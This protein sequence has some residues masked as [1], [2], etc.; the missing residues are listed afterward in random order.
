MLTE[1]K[2]MIEY[3]SR[4]GLYML[5]IEGQRRRFYRTHG[6]AN[7]VLGRFARRMACRLYLE[8]L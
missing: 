5:Q 6:E 4:I 3:E 8:T 7:R 1:D 2:T